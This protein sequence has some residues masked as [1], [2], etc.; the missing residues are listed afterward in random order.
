MKTLPDSRGPFRSEQLRS[1]DPYEL[2]NGHAVYCSPTGG[3]GSKAK[4]A[5]YKV[6]A[7]DPACE[8]VGIDTG[9]SP[10]PGTLRAPDL[11]V[12]RIPDEPG[13]VKGVPRLAVEYADTGQDE[14]DLAT[15]IGEL[16]AAGTELFW[17]VRLHGPRRVEV[18]RPGERMRIVNPGE[19]LEAPGILENPVPVEA[20]YDAD[21]ANDVALRNLLQRQGYASLEAVLDKGKA[22]G[23]L[24][25]LRDDLLAVFGARELELDEEHRAAVAACSDPALLRRWLV[26]AVTASTADDVFS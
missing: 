7:T 3:R 12:G 9:F 26:A 20:L 10:E 4:G 14:D 11:S 13:W 2:S 17:V 6:L 19:T 15:K 5:G 22:E 8:D 1:G 23:E 24:R 18:Y 21:A 25:A 16:L